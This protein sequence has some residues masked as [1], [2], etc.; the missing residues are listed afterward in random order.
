MSLEFL[1]N[2]LN[3]R[4]GLVYDSIYSFLESC[5]YRIDKKKLFF[6]IVDKDDIN[7]CAWSKENEDHIE[8]NKGLIRVYYEYFLS[9]NNYYKNKLLEKLMDNVS[10]EDLKKMSYEAISFSNGNPEIVDGKKIVDERTK[11][12]EIFVSRFILL[13][14]YGHI[15]N[16]HC[17]FIAEKGKKDVV[18]P[19]RYADGIDAENV[20]SLDIRTLEMDAD[21]F[22]ATQSMYHLLFLYTEFDSQVKCE[23]IKKPM[24]LFFWWA[25]A[26]RSHFL[27]CEDKFADVNNFTNDMKH[28]PSNIRWDMIVNTV[29]EIVEKMINP[30]VVSRDEVKKRIFDGA[31]EAEKVFNELKYTKYSWFDE[32]NENEQYDYYKKQVDLNWET[33]VKQLEKYSRCP[34]YGGSEFAQ[35]SL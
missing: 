14:E 31:I 21:M 32:I 29:M 34:L 9:V 20:T 5:G 10:E 30:D 25:F 19:M 2:D 17:N 28:F 7:G 6:N 3:K 1:I 11:L 24:D 27:L 8:I 26:I 18:I 13:H 16:G 12:L 22:A 23:G 33:L 35:N 4:A 15:F